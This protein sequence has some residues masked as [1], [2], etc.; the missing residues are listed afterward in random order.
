[1]WIVSEPWQRLSPP[2]RNIRF[3]LHVNVQTSSRITVRRY[4]RLKGSALRKRFPQFEIDDSYDAVYQSEA[5]LVD[6]AL[7]NA[8]HLQLAQGRGARILDN[9]PVT[10]VERASNGMITVSNVLS[11]R[12]GIQK[13]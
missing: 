2:S 9:C 5:G 6:A 11:S 13:S 3:A 7:G 10:G 12:G 8:V 1:M 4:D